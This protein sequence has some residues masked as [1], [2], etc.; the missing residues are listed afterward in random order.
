MPI[1]D[2]ISHKEV[3][4]FLRRN[5][6]KLLEYVG[7]GVMANVYIVERNGERSVLKISKDRAKVDFLKT[8]TP[9]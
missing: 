1:E 8:V 9:F 5:N 4:E 3:A 6:W 7:L 2:S